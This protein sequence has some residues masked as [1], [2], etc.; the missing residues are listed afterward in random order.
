VRPSTFEQRVFAVMLLF[1]AV[2]VGPSWLIATLHAPPR[3]FACEMHDAERRVCATFGSCDQR[4]PAQ[5]ER[6][7]PAP[8]GGHERSRPRSA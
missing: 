7:C 6:E 2:W 1:G 4:V 8:A 5:L 3:P